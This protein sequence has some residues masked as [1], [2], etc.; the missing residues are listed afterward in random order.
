MPFHRL[1]PLKILASVQVS[2]QQAIRVNLIYLY[3][4]NYIGFNLIIKNLHFLKAISGSIKIFWKLDLVPKISTVFKYL[5]IFIC[6]NHLRHSLN[7]IPNRQQYVPEQTG[8][9]I[10]VLGRKVTI[11]YLYVG[12]GR[13]VLLCIHLFIFAEWEGE[14]PRT[15]KSERLIKQLPVNS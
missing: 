11:I 8:V 10:D 3:T 2:K 7:K 1:F 9:W 12:R 4:S 5:A 14:H 6:K 13:G 15:D